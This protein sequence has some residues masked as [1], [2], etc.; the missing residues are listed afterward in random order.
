MDEFWF[1][2]ACRS[3]N[4]GDA[5]HCYHC[6]APKSDAT[7]AT[8]EIRNLDGVMLPGVES[9][10]LSPDRAML[11][12]EPYRAAWRIGYV[13]AAIL[14]ATIVFQFGLAT[15]CAI[16][17]AAAMVPDY[18][19]GPWAGPLLLASA[20]GYALSLGLAA[21]VHS[22]FLGRIDGNVQSLGGGQPQFGSARASLWWLESV[23]WF[24]RANLVIWIPALLILGAE[25][26]AGPYSSHFTQRA[27][28][29]PGML[30]AW[31]AF[32]ILG[33]PLK[34]LG[35]PN[36]LLNDLTGRLA[37][38]ETPAGQ[39]AIWSGAWLAAR[40][41]DTVLIVVLV[42]SFEL[43]AILGAVGLLEFA[44]HPDPTSAGLGLTTSYPAL[45][46]LVVMAELAANAIAVGLLA[47]LTVSLCRAEKVRRDWVLAA[48]G[49]P[50]EIRSVS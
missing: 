27:I 16:Q 45:I 8:I 5:E 40:L 24:V 13:S 46:P 25:G 38:R 50:N 6:R 9:F 39:V 2:N 14:L 49:V 44:S 35:R 4:R 26:I 41:I 15:A 32:R 18:S 33:N 3:M 28:L 30:L 31:L 37:L 7:L 47:R 22:A 42:V 12:R 19:A 48:A 29:L 34:S 20:A 43:W 1:C 17:V 10:D 23:L 36:S 21:V 11:S